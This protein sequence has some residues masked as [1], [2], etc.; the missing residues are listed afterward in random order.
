MDM[1]SKNALRK[2]ILAKRDQSIAEDRA[3][4][5]E[6]ILNRFTTSEY[7]KK[8]KV[9]FIFVSFRSEVDTHKIIKKAIEDGKIICVPKVISKEHGMKVYRIKSLED[10]VAGYYG[11]LEPSEKCEEVS[12]N[13]IELAVMPGAAFDREGGRI[14]YGG[15][16]YDRFLTKVQGNI[17]KIALAY[18]LQIIEAVPMEENDIR[19]DDIITN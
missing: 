5:D 4:W 11:I 13:D 12:I 6:E 1:S 10:L 9:I 15:G 2:F 19:I 17:K 18:K 8:S 14:G 7:Y 3:N 16:F